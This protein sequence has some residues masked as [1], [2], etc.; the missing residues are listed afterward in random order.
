MINS[1]TSTYL[2]Y[3]ATVPILSKIKKSMLD[4]IEWG[5]VNAS[6]V[7]FYGRI[8]FIQD[9][10]SLIG[11]LG[12]L[13]KIHEN[14]SGEKK[15]WSIKDAPME[16]VKQKLSSIVGVKIEVTK[17]VAKSKLSQN[18]E[19]DD[20]NGVKKK[21]LQNDKHS[22]YIAMKDISLDRE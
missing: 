19:I 17:V 2:D 4:F 12:T 13:T 22:L 9:L 20:F 3:N 18:K 21:M 7:H 1:N 14:R 16:F 10:K 5:P 15:P 8:F 11:I 6:S